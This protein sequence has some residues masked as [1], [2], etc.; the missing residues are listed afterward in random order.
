MSVVVGSG[1]YVHVAMYAAGGGPT[2]PGVTDIE[3]G[4]YNLIAS[5]S[6]GPIYMWVFR[7]ATPLTTSTSFT[8][9][10]TPSSSSDPVAIGAI[11]VLGDGGVD[12]IGAIQTGSGMSESSSVATS[13]DSELVLFLGADGDSPFSSWGSGQTILPNYPS[14]PGASIAAWGSYQS[15]ATPGTASSTRTVTHNT[16]WT[17]VSIA[18]SPQV[19]WVSISG[20]PF[21][22]VSPIGTSSTPAAL[23]TNNGADF[24]PDTPGTHTNGIQEAIG[25]IPASGGT[26]YL[27][28][29]SYSLSKSL[30]NTGNYQVVILSAGAI[31]NFSASGSYETGGGTTLNG[32]SDILVGTQRTPSEANWHDCYW[33]G[34]GAQI[35]ASGITAEQV[36]AVQHGGVNDSSELVP[37]YN[38]VVDG[39][40]LTN[41]GNTAI[42]VCAN[43]YISGV[44]YA[45]QIRRVR[46]SR[47]RA[48]WST[49]AT[50]AGGLIVQGSTR[51]LLASDLNMDM[52]SV[53]GTVAGHTCFIRGNAGDS[54]N[55]VIARSTFIQNGASGDVLN[56]QG[57]TSGTN[58]TEL[59]L[60]YNIR[61]E[62]CVFDS[63][64]SSTGYHNS[65]G[66]YLND[67]DVSGN[68]GFVYNI[69]F[70]RCEFGKGG[71]NS[72]NVGIT[73][74]SYRTQYGYLRF[75]EGSI[76]AGFSGSLT[77]RGPGD[78]G[79]TPSGW[80]AAVG[81]FTYTNT[82]G[83]EERVVVS[84]GS[85]VSITLNTNPAG[86]VAGAFV[87]RDGDSI[88]VS[89][90]TTKPTVFVTQPL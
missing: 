51:E 72:P 80:S 1:M 53:G 60:V 63:Q 31:L 12:A 35:V 6:S 19:P 81:S 74:E 69:E 50:G 29:G 88:F 65:G 55:L 56:V 40:S 44:T 41:V 23:I 25:S 85:G 21:V 10:V 77:G 49:G 37:G 90:S 61:F 33:F 45:Q 43:N 14:T 79:T 78:A 71:G 3:G 38:L 84:G 86:V 68:P 16:G 27:Q 2:Q 62:D 30:Y 46:V 18:I 54:E 4:L 87:L 9:T 76:P 20:R 32:P 47:I 24:G 58:A 70:S 5:G 83:F 48:T 36:F 39:F 75:S 42:I 73:F 22:T 66:A 64:N 17:A 89:W 15:Q 13:G 7:R 8:V 59:R 34:N 52:T 57:N 26:L 28:P 11:G 67:N 82:H